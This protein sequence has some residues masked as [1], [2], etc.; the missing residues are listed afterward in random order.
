MKAVGKYII[1]TDVEEKTKET[2]GGLLLS[3]K[4]REDIR[5]RQ[6]RVLE[7]GTEVVGVKKD[8]K[9]Y[10]DRHAGFDIEIDSDIYKVIKDSDVVVVIWG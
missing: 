1:I 10:F 2:K 7:I 6:A 3:S 9:I 4:Q 5:Y 8:D